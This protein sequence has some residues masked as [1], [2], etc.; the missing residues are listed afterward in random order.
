MKILNKLLIAMAIYVTSLTLEL[1]AAAAV[2]QNSPEDYVELHNTARSAAGAG[3]VAWDGM[4]ARHAGA[5]A[6]L[7][8][9]GSGS[10]GPA[11]T[12]G[13]YGEVVFRGPPGK[14]S[15]AAADALRAWTAPAA[16]EHVQVVWPGSTKIGCASVVCGGD[17]GVVIV[18]SYEPP[19]EGR[20][21]EE[22]SS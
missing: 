17:G 19:D 12:T 1:A 2:R 21:D 13:G 14:A 4:V 22:G 9:R 8:C 7:G 5:R 3:P 10:A 11:A 6:A 16:R 18:C 20:V 15:A